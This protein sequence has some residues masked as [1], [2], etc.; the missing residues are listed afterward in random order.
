MT[1]RNIILIGMPAVG[2]STVGVLLAKRLGFAFLDTDLIIQ[3]GEG[4]RLQTLITDQG[5]EGFKN[6]EADYLQKLAPYETVIA[7]GGSVVYRDQG[8]VHLQQL[9]RV[10]FLNIG[11]ASLKKRLEGLDERGVVHLP[12]QTIEGI[13]YERQPLY[14]KYSQLTIETD[15]RTPEFIVRAI[16]RALSQDPLF[17]NIKSKG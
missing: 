11:L 14:K 16:C 5:V 17:R 7:T 4:K 12:G 13:F 8:M 1:G 15:G 2:K 10:I 6:M 3:C 9:G